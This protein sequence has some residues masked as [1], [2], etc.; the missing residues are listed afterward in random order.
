MGLPRLGSRM[1]LLLITMLPML[2]LFL[3]LTWY[4]YQSRQEE[5]RAELAERGQLLAAALASSGEYSILHGQF[6]DLKL[7]IHAMLQGDTAIKRVTLLD[8]ARK[9]LLD[10]VSPTAGMSER[11]YYEAP[12]HKR[13]LYVTGGGNRNVGTMGYVQVR[14]SP[15]ALLEKQS[16]RFYIEL[17]V[18]S[19][20]LLACTALAFHM[21]SGFDA[22]LKASMQALRAAD[23]EK[24]RLLRRVNTAVED[25]RKSIALEIHDELNA[26]LIAVRLEA[27]QVAAMAAQ[28]QPAPLADEI[29]SK[30]QNITKLALNLYNS[31][32]SLVRRLRPE[33]LDMLG[34]QGALEEI[35]SQYDGPECRFTLHADGD[36]AGL[37][38]NVAI[39]AYRIV[40]EAM[41]NIVK[42]A[43]ARHATVEIARRDGAVHIAV[44]DDG[45]GFDPA[46]AAEGIGLAGMKERVHALGGRFE[47]AC[48]NGTRVGIVLPERM[49]A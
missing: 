46:H 18:A 1:R 37:D 19:M 27:Q 41:S 24:R 13:L 11:R 21:T 43:H 23:E 35:V 33:V 8:E 9:P 30:A 47:L 31:G 2:V 6:D 22:S 17:G 7:S 45:I 40:Q 26:T 10:V 3:T 36:F 42:H 29:R 49:G 5:V 44:V 14:M 32:R 16:R 34:L 20:G 12:I 25:E 48:A 39:S 4:G 38:S 15:T 28:A